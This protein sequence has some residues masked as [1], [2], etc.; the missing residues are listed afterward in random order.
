MPAILLARHGQASFGAADYDVLSD[1]GARQAAALAAHVDAIGVRPGRV[2]SGSLRRQLDTA[3]PIAARL[4]LAAEVDARWNEY[5]SDEVLARHGDT[6]ARLERRAPG[7][8][9]PP[10]SREVQRLLDSALRG[11]I[12]AGDASPARESWPA[13]AAR[14]RGALDDVG[15]GLASGETA[16]VITSGGVLGA[17]CAALLGAPDD[18]FIAL[19]RVMVNAGITKVVRGGGGTSLISVNEHAYLERADGSLVSYR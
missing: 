6:S 17:V 4:G 10:S 5:E 15:A 9:P 7:G 14:T 18:A 13:F 19:N 12:A 16:L 3:R 2:V 1:L 8:D 11:W